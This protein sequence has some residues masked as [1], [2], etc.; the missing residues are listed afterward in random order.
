MSDSSDDEGVQVNVDEFNK[1]ENWMKGSGTS[2]NSDS[3]SDHED[4]MLLQ[5][6]QGRLGVGAVLRSDR[7]SEAEVINIF[8]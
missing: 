6:R 4:D 5:G 2:R 1:M 8:V 3:D 7:E